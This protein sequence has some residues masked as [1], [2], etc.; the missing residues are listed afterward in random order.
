MSN[1]P[2]KRPAPAPKPA[3]DPLRT[4]PVRLRARLQNAGNAPRSRPALPGGKPIAEAVIRAASK[5][6]AQNGLGHSD[7][8]LAWRDIVG[9]DLARLCRP[10]R[11][12]P[13]RSGGQTLTL[14]IWGAAGP[15]IQHQERQILDRVNRHFGAAVV[16]K[17]SLVQGPPPQPAHAA[18]GA[19]PSAGG[20][21]FGGRRLS[22]SPVA[23][24]PGPREAR[25]AEAREAKVQAH[26]SPPALDHLPD[27]PV[28]DALAALGAAVRRTAR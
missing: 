28:K 17:L 10:F 3:Q 2:A 27:G 11:L 13:A 4:S 18:D 9:P 23:D 5:G 16:T 22:L 8:V 1:P 20:A 15:R 21:V 14:Q 7:L 26:A 12:G 24:A 6:L 25:E 19:A